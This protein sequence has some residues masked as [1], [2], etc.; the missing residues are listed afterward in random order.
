MEGRERSGGPEGSRVGLLRGAF[1]QPTLACAGHGRCL[2]NDLWSHSS[3]GDGVCSRRKSITPPLDKD[4][5]V[6]SFLSRGS[7]VCAYLLVTLLVVAA[8]VGNEP[9]DHLSDYTAR[10]GDFRVAAWGRNVFDLVAR[11]WCTYFN[12][13]LADFPKSRT[14][15]YSA[16][17]GSRRGSGLMV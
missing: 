13:G 9:A 5:V 2:A 7:G 15:F 14:G 3:A 6:L 8:D 16:G 11:R 10:C 1:R 4:R 17:T 12:W